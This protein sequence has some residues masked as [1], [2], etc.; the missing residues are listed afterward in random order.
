MPFLYLFFSEK[1]TTHVRPKLEEMKELTKELVV[2]VVEPVAKVVEGFE[3]NVEKEG[4]LPSAPLISP[5]MRT[6]VRAP[7]A[8]FQMQKMPQCRPHQVK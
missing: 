1:T 6:K 5:V 7:R 4:E 2:P 3:A 8:E